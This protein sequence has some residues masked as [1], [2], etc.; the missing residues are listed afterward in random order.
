MIFFLSPPI[1]SWVFFL[2]FVGILLDIGHPPLTTNHLINSRKV[3]S[4]SSFAS[5]RTNFL[6]WL[7]I[8]RFMHNSM[9]DSIAINTHLS[10][11]PRWIHGSTKH[12]DLWIFKIPTPLA[13]DISIFFCSPWDP[14]PPSASGKICHQYLREPKVETQE[15]LFNGNVKYLRSWQNRTFLT[16]RLTNSASAY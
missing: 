3:S 15:T 13:L 12:R 10:E 11:T 5:L 16:W 6:P 4:S 1:A 14:P 7:V 8:R 9:D 2:S